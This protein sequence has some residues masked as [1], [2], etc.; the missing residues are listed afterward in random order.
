VSFHELSTDVTDIAQ[1][2]TGLVDDRSIQETLSRG[3]DHSGSERRGPRFVVPIFTGAFGAGFTY[4][5]M[6]LSLS[7]PHP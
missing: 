7:D 1:L 4:L 5:D 6:A 3:G 2:M